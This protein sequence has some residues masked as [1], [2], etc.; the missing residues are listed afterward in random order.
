MNRTRTT[1]T[2]SNDISRDST[3]LPAD[4]RVVSLSDMKDTILSKI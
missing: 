1:I 4:L 3:H 2:A